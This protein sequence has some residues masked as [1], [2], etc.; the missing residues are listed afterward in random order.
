MTTLTTAPT[1]ATPEST[2]QATKWGTQ[3]ASYPLSGWLAGTLIALLLV[4]IARQVLHAARRANAPVHHALRQLPPS[5]RSS[6]ALVCVRA[7]AAV[8]ML[9]GASAV[10]IADLAESVRAG[11]AWG[12]FDAA[13]AAGLSAHASAAALRFFGGA[14]HLGDSIALAV[15]AAGIAC[16]LWGTRHRLLATGWVIA[17]SGNG[18]MTRVLKHFFERVRP[19][20]THGM[21]HAEGFSFPSGHSSASM[22]AYTLLAYLATRLLPRRWHLP[23]ALLAGVVIFTTGWSRVVLQVHYASDVLAGWLLG[24]TWALCAVLVI[25]SVSRWRR[26]RA[27]VGR[28]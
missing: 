20:H 12:A 19:V 18:V 14:T 6:A 15:M 24:G 5:H 9:A 10:L 17:L 23:L 21:A 4:L 28:T 22:V 16:A 27:T 25:E 11:G 13:L 7:C 1:L 3:L 26:T 8:L 2:Q